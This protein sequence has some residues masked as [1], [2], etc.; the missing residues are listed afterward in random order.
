M[1]DVEAGALASPP[2]HPPPSLPPP[3]ADGLIPI[4]LFIRQLLSV[5]SMPIL[6]DASTMEPPILLLGAGERYHLF[7]SHSAP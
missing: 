6:R 5:R 3:C 2:A 1:S 4:A 7:L